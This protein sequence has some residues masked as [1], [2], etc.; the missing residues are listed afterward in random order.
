MK[1]RHLIIV[2]CCLLV[3][4]VTS[5][6]Q[7]P[8]ATVAP[9]GTPEATPKPDFRKI[10]WGASLADVIVAEGRAADRNEGYELVYYG[11]SVLGLYANLVYTF[12]DLGECCAARYVFVE[13][14]ADVDDYLDDYRMI[15]AS[16]TEKYGDMRMDNE[17]W[18]DDTLKD[19]E[20][21]GMAVCLGHLQYQSAWFD[22]DLRI[23]L[24]MWGEDF[25][26]YIVLKYMPRGIETP[27]PRPSPTISPRYDPNI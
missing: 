25:E 19:Y 3:I 14:H 24:T 23:L 12:N 22:D 16:I 21:L 1:Q 11:E 15:Q 2:L 5:C 6:A 7:T 8:T 26:T 17:I 4:L 27:A 10:K 18:I 9:T 13:T 20:S